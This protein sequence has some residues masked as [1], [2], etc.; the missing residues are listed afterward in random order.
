MLFADLKTAFDKMYRGKLWDCLREKGIRES[1]VRR[2]EK[3]Y[4]GTEVTIRTKLGNT[5]SFVMKRG[6][7]QEC[8]MSSLLFNLYI[9]DLD[10]KFKGRGINKQRIWNLAY[11]DDIILLVKNRKILLP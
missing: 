3:T 5:E 6:V 2:I 4:K 10:E 1:L 7:K 11:A 8:V 9:A